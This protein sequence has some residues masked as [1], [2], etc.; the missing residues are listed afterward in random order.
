MSPNRI[1]AAFLDATAPP[2]SGN[3][4]LLP[5][6]TAAYPDLGVTVDLICRLDAL[7]V[8]A[9]EIGFPFSDSIADGPV[10]QDSFHRALT[11]GFRVR[12]LFDAIAAVRGQ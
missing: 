2:G 10:I 12:A 3:L 8:A 1:D 11:T 6:L 5:Y 9:V 4:R 7:G